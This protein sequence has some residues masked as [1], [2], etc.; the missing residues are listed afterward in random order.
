MRK[1][2]LVVVLA[3]GILGGILDWFGHWYR[4]HDNRTVA[5]QEG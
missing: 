4:S 1:Q 3:F 5:T 2:I